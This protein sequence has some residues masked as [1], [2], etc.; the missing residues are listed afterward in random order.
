MDALKAFLQKDIGTIE[1]IK[2]CQGGDISSAFHIRTLSGSNYF[3]KLNRR[4]L[5][6]MFAAEAEGLRLLAE[7]TSFRVP[8]V[9]NAFALG[10]KAGL[11]MEWIEP[12]APDDTSWSQFWAALG[13]MHSVSGEFFGLRQDNFIGPLPQQNS[14]D[15][16]WIEFWIER[17]VSPMVALATEKGH[18]RQT[19]IPVFLALF[20]KVRT[21]FKDRIFEP[22]LLH[23]DLWKGNAFFDVNGA[24]VIVDP[25]VYWGWPEMELAFMD[26]FGGFEQT[27]RA[28]Y[29]PRGLETFLGDSYYHIWQIYPLLVHTILFGGTYQRRLMTTVKHALE[30]F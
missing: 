20:E 22:R 17:R 26:L 1:T 14:P 6:G 2:P 11:L 18:L 12:G 7:K 27:G 21:G 29:Q 16:N 3:L 8:R 9:H 30:L 5:E 19:E 10:D 23:G 28:E 4:D 13:E 15:D 25:A 24:P